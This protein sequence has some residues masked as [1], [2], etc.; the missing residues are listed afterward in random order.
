MH[1]TNVDDALTELN[2]TGPDGPNGW[3][4]SAGLCDIGIDVG[5]VSGDEQP[6]QGSMSVRM[7]ATFILAVCLFIKLLI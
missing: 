4:Y 6:K 7:Q 2:K 1:A 5:C 3:T